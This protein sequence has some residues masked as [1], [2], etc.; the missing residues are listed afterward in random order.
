VCW[1]SRFSV[2]PCLRC[3]HRWLRSTCPGGR[4]ESPAIQVWEGGSTGSLGPVL[5]RLLT[6]SMG[7]ETCPRNRLAPKYPGTAGCPRRGR[8]PSFATKNHRGHP[9]KTWDAAGM[10]WGWRMPAAVRS[11][12]GFSWECLISCGGKMRGVCRLQGCRSLVFR[13][14]SHQSDHFIQ[15]RARQKATAVHMVAVPAVV[16]PLCGL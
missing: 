2:P 16:Q 14:H 4:L 11:D 15:C 1:P 5:P 3:L 10:W 13:C 9:A 8:I 7:G 12:L 6:R